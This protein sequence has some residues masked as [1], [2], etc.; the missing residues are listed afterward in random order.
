MTQTPQI[1]RWIEDVRNLARAKLGPKPFS[2]IIGQIS[3]RTALDKLNGAVLAGRAGRGKTFALAYKI[4]SILAALAPTLSLSGDH[5][6]LF[7][8]ASHLWDGFHQGL[9]IDSNV[10]WA[11]I[12]DWGMEYRE[13]FA[14]SR[15]DEWF[16]IRESQTEFHLFLTTNLSRK[17]FL[18]Q[19]G[20]ERIVSR[21]QGMTDWI[22][23]TG[24]DRR[25]GWGA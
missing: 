3:Q 7:T 15:A 6:F 16:R 5:P 2:Y 14:I 21:I 23:F 22:E 20:M 8:S 13:P 1:D 19:D 12:D 25:K 17:Q 10:N 11:F 24:A 4:D 9:E 18:Q